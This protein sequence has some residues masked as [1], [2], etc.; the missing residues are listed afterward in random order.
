[1]RVGKQIEKLYHKF[2]REIDFDQF[3]TVAKNRIMNWTFYEM[4]GI[5]GK[6]IFRVSVQDAEEALTRKKLKTGE[7][8]DD[9]DYDH[10][11]GKLW[12]KIQE[13]NQKIDKLKNALG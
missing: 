13:F 1:M 2:G 4:D 3:Q 8:I 12:R 9:D 11:M 10:I 5:L 7:I 6:C